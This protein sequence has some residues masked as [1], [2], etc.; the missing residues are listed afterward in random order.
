MELM[1]LME[2]M[3]LMELME[4]ISLLNS[5]S[6]NGSCYPFESLKHCSIDTLVSRM[7]I[8]QSNNRAFNRD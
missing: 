3:G 1:E 7:P 6:L 5:G 8:N 2:L 4:V